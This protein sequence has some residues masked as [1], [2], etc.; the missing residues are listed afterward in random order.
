MLFIIKR[1][2]LNIEPELLMLVLFYVEYVI[3]VTKKLIHYEWDNLIV[4][5]PASI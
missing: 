2:V 5:L 3:P 4:T 1:W